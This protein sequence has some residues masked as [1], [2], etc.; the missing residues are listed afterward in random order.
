M[1]YLLVGQG[2]PK[3]VKVMWAIV[4]NLGFLPE[5]LNQTLFM[6]TPHTFNARYRDINLEL[7]WEFPPWWLAFIVL[8]RECNA[9]CWRKIGISSFTHFRVLSTIISIHQ[10]SC[11]HL[12][13]SGI[14]VLGTT[15]DSMICFE[16]TLAKEG[17][18]ICCC[19]PTQ[20]LMAE[21]ILD[22]EENCLLLFS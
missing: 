3:A 7:S 17:V 1:K 20:K 15:K 2:G 16:A 8:E 18:Y 12:H 19:R 11:V 4:I 6:S 5:L 9:G 13:H 22:P 14:T 21:N 10:V